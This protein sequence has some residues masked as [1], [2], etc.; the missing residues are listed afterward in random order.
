MQIN[1]YDY[2]A[3]LYDIY[4]P[5]TFDIDFFI[6]E[7]KKTSGEVLE[8][9]SGTGRVSIPLLEA[10]VKLTCVDLSAASNAILAEKLRQKGLNADVYTQDVCE[11]DLQ[12]QFDMI[13]IP[14]HS[15]THI[16]S[17]E[18]QRKALAR[19]KQ[20]LLPGGTFICT[21]GN[22][23]L[24]QIVVDGQLRLFRKYPLP[25][26]DGMLL[27][28]IAE[29]KNDEDDRVVEAMQFYE[30]YD[31][32]GVLQCKRLLE[33][34]FRLSSKEEFE[35]LAKEAGFQTTALYGDYAYSEYNAASPFAIWL[36][37]K[38]G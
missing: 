6:Q 38:V 28:W 15:F 18:N 3:D 12:K 9:M 33:L 37:E 23:N 11:L 8:L 22:S 13:I 36:L 10:G 27:L 2:I 35:Q 14:F 21:L 19:I 29:N 17:L 5:V 20:H 30:E 16:T 31:A 32:G 25:D 7:T 4:V 1:N 26:T 34:H 24:R